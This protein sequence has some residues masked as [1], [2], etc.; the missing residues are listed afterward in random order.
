M[1]VEFFLYGGTEQAAINLAHGLKAKGHKVKIFTTSVRRNVSGLDIVRIRDFAS[2][3]KLIDKRPDL[4]LFHSPGPLSYA[5]LTYAKTA[6]IT[7]MGYYHTVPDVFISMLTSGSPNDSKRQH[8][9][10]SSY[11]LGI[12]KGMTYGYLKMFYN[13]TDMMLCPSRSLR[14]SLIQN[15]FKNVH[16]LPYGLSLVGSSPKRKAGDPLNLIFVGQLRKDKEVESVIRAVAHL[17]K[18]GKIAM[19]DIV[20]VGPREKHIKDEIIKRGLEG[21]VRLFGL[22]PHEKLGPIYGSHDIYVNAAA[23]ETF[24][25]AMAEALS[26]GLPVVAMK[27]H[28]SDELIADAVNGYVVSSEKEMADA[29]IKVTRGYPKLSKGAVQ[30]IKKRTIKQFT[31]DFLQ[32]CGQLVS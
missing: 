16:Y 26:H 11:L 19:L 20:G 25:L 6:G 23:S 24:G 15:G 2:M 27:S 12:P 13:S 28:G 29:I 18:K 32:L 4:I 17:Q 1:V 21:N 10:M 7:T 9:A 8:N 5:I 14:S 30:S 31:E 3:S 22:V